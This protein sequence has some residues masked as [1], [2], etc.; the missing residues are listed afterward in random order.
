MAPLA[1]PQIRSGIQILTTPLTA[2]RLPI[3]E[4]SRPTLK[5]GSSGNAVYVTSSRGTRPTLPC[6][7][8]NGGTK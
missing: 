8:W 6:S 3:R 1:L 5:H 2:G 7:L 4:I